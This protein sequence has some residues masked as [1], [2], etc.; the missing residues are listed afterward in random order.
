MVNPTFTKKNKNTLTFNNDAKRLFQVI[1]REQNKKE[2]SDDEDPKI[3]V[4]ILISKMS[5]YYEKI[6]NTVDYKEEHLLMKN[7]IERIL[8]RQIIIEGAISIKKINNQEIAT[9]LL[10]E[11][12]RAA[13]LPNNQIKEKKI[14]E[15]ATVLDRY[16]KLR[17]FFLENNKQLSIKQKNDLGGWIISLAAS[18]IEERLGRNQIDLTV[19]DIM[20]Q[21]LLRNIQLPVDS[22]YE[23][24]R[25]I[26]IFIG[27]YRSFLK[28]DRDMLGLVLLRYYNKNWDKTSDEEIANISKNIIELRKII[29]NQLDHPLVGQ[30]NRI[31]GHYTVFFSVLVDQIS[32]D[33]R[34]VYEQFY[35]DPIAFNR[36]IKKVCNKRYSD[37]RK[38]LWRAAIRSIIY[39]FITKSIFVVMLE[40]PATMWFG[41]KVNNISLAI[42]IIFPA[43]LLFLVV[44][45]TRLPGEDNS[46]KI[47]RGIEEIIF[48][49]RKRTEPFQLRKPVERTKTLNTVF[50]V[51]YAITFFLSF[52]S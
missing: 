22:E 35:S 42:N 31:I 25:D 36:Q 16:L 29:N 37:A 40:I 15:I 45:F 17:H 43:F 5:F 51:I 38:K 47:I 44:L 49:E 20:Y 46:F 26:Q 28:F 50:G 30:L 27:I 11:L 9:H 21:T 48:V 7:A 4:S 32:T 2:P 39:I 6:R 1:F 10:T 12:I 19:I 18:D 3:K 24:D 33:P 41:E 23:K 14:N 13:Y 8:K 34:G 52:K